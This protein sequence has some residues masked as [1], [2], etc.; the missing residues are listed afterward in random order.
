MGRTAGQGHPAN[1]VPIRGGTS[2]LIFGLFILTCTL[3]IGLYAVADARN[4]S[5]L[6]FIA[7]VALL[8][9]CVLVVFV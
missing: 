8:L 6:A 2:D 5:R 1:T 9:S 4:D 7:G 3:A